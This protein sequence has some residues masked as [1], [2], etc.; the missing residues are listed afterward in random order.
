MTT[1]DYLL[2]QTAAPSETPVT[3][4]EVKADLKIEQTAE[5]TMLTDLILAA[6]EYAASVVGKSFV[7]QTW[8]LSIRCATN[9]IHLPV[10]PAISIESITYFDGDNTSQ[11]LDKN[12]FYLYSGEDW[13]YIEPKAGTEWP[14]LFD[15]LDALTIEFV[16]GF[17]A[18][19]KVPGT[20]KR[21]I[22]LTV[23][24]WYRNRSPTVAGTIVSKV[25]MSVDTLL[26]IHR[27]GWVG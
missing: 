19:E 16:A 13:A 1:G 7:T 6:T 4:D 21:A 11:T 8:A 25:P 2:N 5:D 18:A 10:F 20:I 23:A 3:L 22:R 24:H 15:R 27:V 12:D 9:R 26:S 17:G 14:A